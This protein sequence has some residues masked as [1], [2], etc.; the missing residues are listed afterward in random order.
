LFIAAET[1]YYFFLRF[2]SFL[3]GLTEAFFAILGALEGALLFL[4]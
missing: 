1:P 4:G 3:F 2:S